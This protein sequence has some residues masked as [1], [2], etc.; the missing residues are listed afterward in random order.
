MAVVLAIVIFLVD[1]GLGRFHF[2]TG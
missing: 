1:P 2:V